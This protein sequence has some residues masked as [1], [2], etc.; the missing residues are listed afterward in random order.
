L[1]ERP[2][3]LRQHALAITAVVGCAVLFSSFFIARL[4]PSVLHNCSLLAPRLA[5]SATAGL[6]LLVV[7]LLS[8]SWPSLSKRKPE[9]IPVAAKPS[10]P[11]PGGAPAFWNS[12][13]WNNAA[14]GV[15][16]CDLSITTAADEW[17][18]YGVPS[19]EKYRS[20]ITEGL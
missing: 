14:S 19:P 3:L 6:K 8:Q 12:A 20:I 5:P 15:F 17:H 13:V 10:A 1:R 18:G 4:P 2:T 9:K 16:F 7:G 11:T